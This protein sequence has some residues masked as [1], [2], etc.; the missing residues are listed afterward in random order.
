MHRP[1]P[2]HA[3]QLCDAAGVFAIGL[4]HHGRERRLDVARLQEHGV[5][6]GRHKGRV[7]PLRQGTGLQAKAHQWQTK[8]S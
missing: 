8:T 7:K 2:A 3:K 5:M 6:A 1:E 4:H